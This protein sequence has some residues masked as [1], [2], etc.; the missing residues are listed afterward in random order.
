MSGHPAM[1]EFF[2][3]PP[4]SY[5]TIQTLD[6]SM[7]CERLRLKPKSMARP[8]ECQPELHVR[9]DPMHPIPSQDET[10]VT[11]SRTKTRPEGRPH[12]QDPRRV[13][14]IGGVMD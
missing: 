1:Q 13:Q 5:L 9:L 14:Q 12:F 11:S 10:S 3:P 6:C 7:Y 8:E 2:N 4:S